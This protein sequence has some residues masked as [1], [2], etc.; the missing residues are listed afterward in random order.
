MNKI[1]S[2]EHQRVRSVVE[3]LSESML[4]IPEYQRPYKWKSHNI[5]N[6]LNDI[7]AQSDKSAYRLGTIV[8]NSSKDNEGNPVLNIVDGQQ[9]CLTLMLI[10]L[11]VTQL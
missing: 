1:R 10:V 9:R 8:L 4:R 3:L 11:A 7:K 2:L 6:L 5:S